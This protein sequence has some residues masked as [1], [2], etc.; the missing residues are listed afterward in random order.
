MTAF[1]PSSTALVIAIVIPRSLKEPV[2]L[3]PSTLRNT[4]HPV[5]RDSSGAGSSGVAPSWSVITGVL[6]LTGRRDR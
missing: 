1:D 3:A 2:G 4:S 6:S 5:R